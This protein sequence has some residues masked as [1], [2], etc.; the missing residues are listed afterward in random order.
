MRNYQYTFQRKYVAYYMF[1][2]MTD[3]E[4]QR[5]LL[6][7]KIIMKIRGKPDIQ[8]ALTL[9]GRENFFLT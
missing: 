4:N 9:I 7:D 5:K 8:T 3:C 1:S 6:F 2:Y